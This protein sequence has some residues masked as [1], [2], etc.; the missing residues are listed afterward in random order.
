MPEIVHTTE[1]SQDG[2]WLITRQQLLALDSIVESEWKKLLERRE[3]LINAEVEKQLT[4]RL[5][6]PSKPGRKAEREEIREKLYDIAASHSARQR[7]A[8]IYLSDDRRVAVG[9]FEEALREPALL[10]ERARGFSLYLRAAELECTLKAL[11]SSTFLH[12][13]VSPE[14]DVAAKGLFAAL[15][16]WVDTVRPPIWQRLWLQARSFWGQWFAWVLALLIT[17]FY[18]AALAPDTSAAARAARY[19][20]TLATLKSG[21]SATNQFK[22]LELILSYTSG[23]TPASKTVTVPIWAMW[24]LC[25]GPLFCVALSFAPSVVLGIGKGEESI[26]RW[27][28]WMKLVGVTFPL[29]VMTAFVW[30]KI[31]AFLKGLF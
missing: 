12:I 22:A 9:S 7:I 31:L 20:E 18:I 8:V 11:A 6:H 3:D 4:S 23:A 19:S 25:G 21:V 30:P 28:R 16:G 27:N 13:E 17:L 26:R 10:H 24:I 29:W 2:P 1:I 5:G 14:R 15:R